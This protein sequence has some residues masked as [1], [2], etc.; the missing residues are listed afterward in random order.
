MMVLLGMFAI[1]LA[2]APGLLPSASRPIFI[3]LMLAYIVAMGVCLLKG[4]LFTGIAG[5]FLPPVLL[6]GAVC[7]AR[8]GSPWA[9]VRHRNDVDKQLR[10]AE[11]YRP[12]S[13]RER[14]PRRVLNAI[15]GALPASHYLPALSLE[16]RGKPALDGVGGGLKSTTSK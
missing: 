12:G 16:G 4:K 7:L 6:V 13:A 3:G 10:A 15:G 14:H 8:P 11:R 5:L 2:V 1:P 9:H